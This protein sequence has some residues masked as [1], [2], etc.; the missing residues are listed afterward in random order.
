MDQDPKG[1]IFY[2]DVSYSL[3]QVIIRKDCKIFPKC[4]KEGR[5]VLGGCRTCDRQNEYAG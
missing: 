3:D 2:T 5:N 4:Y 1:S